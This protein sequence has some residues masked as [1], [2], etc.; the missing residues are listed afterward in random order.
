MSKRLPDRRLSE[1][2]VRLAKQP[3]TASLPIR[4]TRFES[5]TV[6]RVSRESSEPTPDVLA[7][8]SLQSDLFGMIAKLA[9]S[10][11]CPTGLVARRLCIRPDTNSRG[12]ESHLYEDDSAGGHIKRPERR[13]PSEAGSCSCDPNLTSMF[14][15]SSCTAN[16][17]KVSSH[18]ALVAQQLFL[19]VRG[20]T[21]S[22]RF[23]RVLRRTAKRRRPDPRS[24]HH[25]ES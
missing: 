18:E 21:K 7:V 12:G 16:R 2:Q 22:L 13:Q 24:S 5:R 6:P 1:R 14:S 25:A 8:R 4:L 11:L 20:G 17:S 9:A 3:T 15:R 19:P 10:G 23:V